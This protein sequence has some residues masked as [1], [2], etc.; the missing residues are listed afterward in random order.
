MSETLS[1]DNIRRVVREELESAMKDAER[2]RWLREKIE[3]DDFLIARVSDWGFTSWSG[4]DP[5][6]YIDAV[7]AAEG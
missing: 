3:N 7:L 6:R 1:L 5:D 4:D 2:Y